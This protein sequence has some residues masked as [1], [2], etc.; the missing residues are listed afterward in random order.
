VPILELEPEAP[1]RARQR[2]QRTTGDVETVRSYEAELDE[3]LLEMFALPELDLGDVFS[4][5]A[6]ISARLTAMRIHCVRSETR[7][8]A[9]LRTR[10]IDPLLEEVDRQF[11]A[12]SRQF[13]VRQHEWEISKGGV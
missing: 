11:K 4:R 3:Y 9:A 8:L 1:E 7:L 10:Q 13:A 5:L 12:W 6:A 2:T